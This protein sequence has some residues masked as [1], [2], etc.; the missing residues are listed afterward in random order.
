MR[1]EAIERLL[2]AVFRAGAQPASPLAAV[3]A[4]MEALHQPA[5]SRLAGLDLIFDPRRTPDAFVPLLARWLDLDRLLEERPG[6]A[7]PGSGRPPRDRSGRLTDTIEIGRLREL[8]AAA[9]YLSRWRGTAKGLK[10]FLETATGVQGFGIDEQVLGQNGRPRPFHLKVLVPAAAAPQL[11]LVRR[12]VEL[13][14]PAY[15]TF[16]TEIALSPPKQA[17]RRN[18]SA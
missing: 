5:E 2:P 11:P 12:I 17:R 13:E 4:A 6:M 16:E 15:E 3:L 7:H 14:K 10:L 1:A 18:G 9:A 8:T